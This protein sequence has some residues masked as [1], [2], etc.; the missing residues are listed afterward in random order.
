MITT[1]AYNE[2]GVTVN[3]KK[4]LRN[5]M[6]YRQLR[7]A[8]VNSNEQPDQVERSQYA[9]L[10][11]FVVDVTGLDWTPPRMGENTKKIEASYQAFIDAVPDFD[12]FNALLNVVNEL[13][14]PL[15]DAVQRPNEALTD[16]ER[17]DP[18]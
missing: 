13:H 15:A 6:F 7:D 18:N 12:L 5:A 8:L 2:N 11:A 16:A 3:F 4:S 10:A 14:T 17:A 9:W 1:A